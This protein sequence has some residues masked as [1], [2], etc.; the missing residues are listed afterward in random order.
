MHQ[1]GKKIKSSVIADGIY[2]YNDTYLKYIQVVRTF[3]EFLPNL[4]NI[5]YVDNTGVYILI[6]VNDL[7]QTVVYVGKSGNVLERVNKHKKDKDKDF[8]TELFIIT[9]NDNSFGDSQASHIENMLY[10]RFRISPNIIVDNDVVPTK[11]NLN[12]DESEECENYGDTIINIISQASSGR[13]LITQFGKPQDSRFFLKGIKKC[14]LI[15]TYIEGKLIIHK[16]S[17]VSK[18]LSK[19]A[20]QYVKRAREELVE[21]GTFIEYK[22]LLILSRDWVYDD[23]QRA[24]NILTGTNVTKCKELWKNY[25][26]VSLQDFI[27]NNGKNEVNTSV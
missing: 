24:T 8:F 26:N 18:V 20:A 17:K 7:G 4:E 13:F 5:K 16:D 3:R 1:F 2:R 6:G 23:I 15:G 27:D 25:S 10:N 12:E 14:E 19:E 21:N 9:T 11:G 22:D